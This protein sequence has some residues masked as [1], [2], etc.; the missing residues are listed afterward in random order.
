M[1]RHGRPEWEADATAPLKSVCEQVGSINN[2]GDGACDGTRKGRGAEGK[3]S[4]EE[5][6]RTA[7]EQ[8]RKS[9]T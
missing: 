4:A 2:C 6:T 9:R 7:A 8:D 1:V 3:C 5:C